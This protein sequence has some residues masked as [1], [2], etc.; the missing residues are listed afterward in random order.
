MPTAQVDTSAVAAFETGIVVR[1]VEPMM[2]FY[3]NVLGFDPYGEVSLPGI[4][5]RGLRL[6]NAI[7]KL[8]Y[9]AAAGE[10]VAHSGFPPGLRYITLRVTNIKPL[11][12]RCLAY[13]CGVVLALEEC[14]SIQGV[15]YEHSVL[16]DP[17]GNYVEFVQGMPYAPPSDDFV[18]GRMENA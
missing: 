16:T 14:T 12:D 1:N 4:H 7:L 9:F 15:T 6:G 17:E 2:E 13:G 3:R 8:T 18:A 10:A 5:V 11:Y